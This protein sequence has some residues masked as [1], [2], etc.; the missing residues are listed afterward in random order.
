MRTFTTWTG[1]DDA[2]RGAAAVIG[3]FDGVHI[4]HR[5]VIELARMHA[6]STGA[7]LGIVTFEPHPREVFAPTSPPFRLMNAETKAH[8]LAKLGIEAIYQLEFTEKLF[9]LTPKEFAQ[10]V[11]ADGLGLSHVVIG[12]DFR[13]GKGRAGNTVDLKAFGAEMG[14]AVTIAQLVETDGAEVSSTSIRQ[15]LTD[16]RP[17]DAAGMLGHWYRIDSAVLHGEKRG[18]ELGYP[19]AN[20]SISGLHPPRF[21][22]YAVKVDVLTGPHRGTYDG[23]ASLGVRPMFGRNQANLETFLLDFAADLYDAHLSVALVDFLRPEMTFDS[24]DALTAQMAA[25][26]AKARIILAEVS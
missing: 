15:A 25:D 26:C 4:G 7:P 18:R 3:N 20:M 11:I 8:R 1:L 2:D 23:A 16:G 24:L 21:G 17:R 22:V 6:D 19:T 13:F 12:S 14:F 9:R 10:N 5:A